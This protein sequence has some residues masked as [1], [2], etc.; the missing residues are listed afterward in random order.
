MG[1]TSA[2]DSLPWFVK[3]V[4]AITLLVL[5]IIIGIDILAFAEAW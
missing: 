4:I 1:N 3:V 2:D 5:L